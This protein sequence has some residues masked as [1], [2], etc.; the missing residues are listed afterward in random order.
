MKFELYQDGRL[1][2][3]WRLKA[4]NGEIIAVS[5]ESYQHKMDCTHAIDLVR[6]SYN[7]PTY[8]L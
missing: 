2:W 5:S 6:A 7:A 1:E 4:R 8:Q 3:R